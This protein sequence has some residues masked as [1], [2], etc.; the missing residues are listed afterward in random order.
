MEVS[1]VITIH[2]F[3]FDQHF[4]TAGESHDFWELVYADREE[5]LCGADGREIRLMPGEMLF[6]KPMEFHTLAA[7][8]KKAPTVLIVS[9]ECKSPAMGFFAGR[10]LTPQKRDVRF[11]YA[12]VD[13]AKRT[14]N[15][16]FSD[17]ESKKMELLPSPT[18]GGQQLI[19]N[20]L[21]ILLIDLMRDLTETREGNDTFLQ[22]GKYESKL[23]AD[24]VR[25]LEENVEGSLTVDE[26]CRRIAYGRAWAF[27]E[28]KKGTGEGIMAYYTR[29][30]IDRAKQLLRE[31][32]LSVRQIA[33]LLC[34]DTP[35]YFSKTFKRLTGQT[36]SA[37]QKMKRKP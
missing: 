30:K 12:L 15:I 3:E 2:H 11:L 31:G 9:F 20:Y 32:E 28:F 35:S 26:L 19:K 1:R 17:P 14:F 7:N 18:L 37:Y 34:F 21:E 29:L 33:E 6:H 27:R 16:P 8:G 13:E 5:I 10:K 36:P 23:V 24:I 22:S 25:I 4:R